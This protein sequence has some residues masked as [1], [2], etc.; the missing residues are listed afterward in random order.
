MK[1]II[2]TLYT[3]AT[4]TAMIAGMQVTGLALET[5]GASGLESEVSMVSDTSIADTTKATTDNPNP[6]TGVESLAI[7][8]AV[9]LIAAATAAITL[10]GKNKK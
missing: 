1:N 6:D 4:I 8:G 2:K 10:T 3:A 5:S 9:A 7:P